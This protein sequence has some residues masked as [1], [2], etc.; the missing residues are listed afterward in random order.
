M[1]PVGA[2]RAVV[3]VASWP[4]RRERIPS[5]RLG[6]GADWDGGVALEGGVGL[7]VAVLSMCCVRLLVTPG[8]LEGLEAGTLVGLGLG[9]PPGRGMERGPTKPPVLLT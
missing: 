5:K 8:I 1:E 4:E 2:S 3:P 6:V 9:V 7:G